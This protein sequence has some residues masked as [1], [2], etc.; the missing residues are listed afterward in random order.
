MSMGAASVSNLGTHVL[1]RAVLKKGGMR[2][3][4]KSNVKL[5]VVVQGTIPISAQSPAQSAR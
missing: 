1:I 3:G 4:R 5:G 2:R